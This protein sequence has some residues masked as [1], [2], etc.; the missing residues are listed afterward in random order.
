MKQGGMTI[1]RKTREKSFANSTG[2]SNERI[3]RTAAAREG[4]A[5]AVVSAIE[6]T[7]QLP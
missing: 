6:A 3:K 2:A 5:A 1:A 7:A 4:P